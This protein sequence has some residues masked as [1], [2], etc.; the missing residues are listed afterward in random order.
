[1]AE[2]W[3][4][5]LP[6]HQDITSL[7]NTTTGVW[8][9]WLSSMK[10]HSFW[11]LFECTLGIIL[12]LGLKTLLPQSR[13]LEL[14]ME[15]PTLDFQQ[16]KGL[17]GESWSSVQQEYKRGCFYFSVFSQNLDLSPT[18]TKVILV[19]KPNHMWDQGSHSKSCALYTHHP[20][21]LLPCKFLVQDHST[22]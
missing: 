17:L 3:E 5:S 16:G 4:H 22:L 9:Y 8:E 14:L 19:P 18:L 21:Q 6:V 12:K 11:S 15:L 10:N 20:T 2:C 1:M 13:P 7:A